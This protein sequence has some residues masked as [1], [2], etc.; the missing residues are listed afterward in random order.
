MI[1][2]CSMQS[3]HDKNKTGI[4]GRITR[5]LNDKQSRLRLISRVGEHDL[6]TFLVKLIHIDYWQDRMEECSYTSRRRFRFRLGF[7]YENDS[8]IVSLNLACIAE[9]VRTILCRNNSHNFAEI[10]C[11][12]FG[13][14]LTPKS[15]RVFIVKNLRSPL[16]PLVCWSNIEFQRWF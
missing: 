16:S 4:H 5:N 7:F 1:H 13:N 6:S 11:A 9:I 10:I 14:S 12:D 2:I 3:M 8:I 15:M